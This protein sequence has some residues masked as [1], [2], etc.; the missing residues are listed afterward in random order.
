MAYDSI[1]EY[2]LPAPN[3]FTIRFERFFCSFNNQ[4]YNSELKVI[5]TSYKTTF[6]VHVHFGY[7]KL[8]AEGSL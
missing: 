8:V 1:T 2:F 3:S 6:E 5:K 4:H 7:V